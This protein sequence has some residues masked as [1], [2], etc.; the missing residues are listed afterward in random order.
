MQHH[1]VEL[2]EE[3]Y[4]MDN[5]LF[6]P[7]D[8]GAERL[9]AGPSPH[10]HTRNISSESISSAISQS[11]LSNINHPS[12][13][14]YRRRRPSP[15]SATRSAYATGPASYPRSS[16]RVQIEPASDDEDELF[17]NDP[18]PPDATEEEKARHKRRKN[19]LAARRSRKR[20]MQQFE[21][22]E[23]DNRRLNREK[24]IWMERALTLERILANNGLPYPN[25]NR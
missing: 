1:K 6:L 9:Q 23:E 13:E 24:D 15:P 10:T 3:T 25:F 11:A 5:L 19:T 2:Q 16:R 14:D 17:D 12:I 8:S 18:L 20:R 22:L 4:T 21:Q 7:M